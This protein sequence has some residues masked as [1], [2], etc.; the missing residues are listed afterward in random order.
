MTADQ[1]DAAPRPTRPWQL[2]VV[3]VLLTAQSLGLLALAAYMGL[4][5]VSGATDFLGA[6]I[7]EIVVV[8]AVAFLLLYLAN[9]LRNFDASGRGLTVFMGLMWLPIGW[10]LHQANL[11]DWTI[12]VWALAVTQTVLLVVEPTRTALGVEN[13]LPMTDDNEAE[14]SS[15]DPKG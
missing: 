15:E 5:T 1:E 4:Q 6:A 10:F 3:I 2:G 13:R 7:G 12:G 11:T 8:V 14:P 9:K